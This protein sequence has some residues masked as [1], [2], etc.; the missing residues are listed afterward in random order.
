MA[1]IKSDLTRCK[2]HEDVYIFRHVIMSPFSALFKKTQYEKNTPKY[3]VVFQFEKDSPLSKKLPTLMQK[4]ALEKMDSKS[5]KHFMYDGDSQGE[6]FKT[7]KE[8]FKN[9]YFMRPK[10]DNKPALYNMDKSPIEEDL[11]ELF[12]GCLINVVV[13][14]YVNTKYG[15][16]VN[17][18]LVAVQKISNPLESL[19]L[20]FG[21][22]RINKEVYMDDLEDLETTEFDD[23]MNFEPKTPF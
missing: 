4:I 2:N 18:S 15:R 23:T 22:S 21:S 12:P 8:Y 3:S 9:H 6:I 5:F 11:G 14:P 10:S 7:E 13:M 17:F 20:D 19:S 1:V 16:Q